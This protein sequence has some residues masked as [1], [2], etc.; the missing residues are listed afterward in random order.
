MEWKHT[1]MIGRKYARLDETRF[2]AEK[3]TV[4]LHLRQQSTRTYMEE[5]SY[6]KPIYL[7]IKEVTH[8]FP[9]GKWCWQYITT[10]F[11]DSFH[12]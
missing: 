5:E 11:L 7:W 10:I 2:Y 4:K 9:P 12:C 6:S 3:S 1:Y 8:D